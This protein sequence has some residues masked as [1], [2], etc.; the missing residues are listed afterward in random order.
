VS[1]NNYQNLAGLQSP[2]YQSYVVQ[3]T[4]LKKPRRSKCLANRVGKCVS[5]RREAARQGG[6]GA[7]IKAVVQEETPA[8]EPYKWEMKHYKLELSVD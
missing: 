4:R 5:G 7:A 3:S 1:S 6:L 2:G 8:P